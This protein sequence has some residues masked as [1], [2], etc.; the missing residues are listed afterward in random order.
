MPV[1]CVCVCVC[2]CQREHPC[3][4]YVCMSCSIRVRTLR[5]FVCCKDCTLKPPQ[6]ATP[7]THART[8][9]HTHLSLPA[10]THIPPTCTVSPF[11]HPTSFCPVHAALT[12]LSCTR[13]P[14]HA[15]L[16]TLSCTRRPNHSVLY[17]PSCTRCPVHP[18]MYT[19]S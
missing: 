9:V 16:Y 15:V 7:V 14:V 13:Y 18:V 10:S 12:T 8:H 19:P 6:L 4:S 11:A 17:T 2:V 1:L 3:Q 5:M